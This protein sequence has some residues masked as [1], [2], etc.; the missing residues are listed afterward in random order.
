MA[1]GD[2]GKVPNTRSRAPAIDEGRLIEFN[3]VC[4]TR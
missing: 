1:N 2:V 3:V 4:I